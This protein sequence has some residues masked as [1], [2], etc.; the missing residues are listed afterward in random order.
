MVRRVNVAES[1]GLLR[2]A[3]FLLFFLLFE[4]RMVSLHTL[5]ERG[6]LLAKTQACPPVSSYSPI[7]MDVWLWLLWYGW[8]VF[9]L[10]YL[11]LFTLQQERLRGSERKPVS[12]LIV[13]RTRE[14]AES[15]L[16]LRATRLSP[17]LGSGAVLCALQLDSSLEPRAGR[18]A[19]REGLHRRILLGVLAD[20]F[21]LVRERCE[22]VVVSGADKVDERPAFVLVLRRRRGNDAMDLRADRSRHKRISS[23]KANRS[24]CF[25]LTFDLKMLPL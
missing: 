3:A 8:F 1:S 17:R 11:H 19:L 21:G 13:L 24:A 9:E 4:I 6:F 23:E 12:H 18:L 10:Q 7:R 25:R 15:Q 2:C 20:D 14:S 16:T 22:R 5:S